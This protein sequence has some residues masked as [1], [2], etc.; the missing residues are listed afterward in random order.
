MVA[1]GLEFHGDRERVTASVKRI[2]ERGNG[3]D[4]QR[5]AYERRGDLRDVVAD[6]LRETAPS[7]G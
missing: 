3:A 6:V 7:D 4:R 5:A 2:L 1:D